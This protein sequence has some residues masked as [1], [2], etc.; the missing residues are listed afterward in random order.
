MY[1]SYKLDMHRD[2]DYYR[3]WTFL[4]TPKPRLAIIITCCD[5]RKHSRMA[6]RNNLSET[7]SKAR[8][9]LQLIIYLLA[10]SRI[11]FP[12]TQP[13]RTQAREIT[14]NFSAFALFSRLRPWSYL[15]SH[16]GK[17]A[18]QRSTGNHLKQFSWRTPP[19]WKSGIWPRFC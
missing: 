11:G 19:S 15:S 4:H 12:A 9:G 13:V 7:R 1:H 18:R 2:P 5:Q 17:E 14:R 8:S 10:S 3:K 6:T 16:K